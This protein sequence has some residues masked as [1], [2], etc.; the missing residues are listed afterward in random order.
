MSQTFEFYDQRARAAEAEAQGAR[1][2][3][4]RERE[5]RSARAWREMADRQLMIDAERVKVEAARL[6]RRAE[7]AALLEQVSQPN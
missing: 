7:E 5:M 2:E 4:V 1:L 3:N 6:Q